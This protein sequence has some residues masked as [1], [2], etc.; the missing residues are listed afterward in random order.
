MKRKCETCDNYHEKTEAEGECRGKFPEPV[1]AVAKSALG[2]QMPIVLGAWPMLA[3]E[4]WCAQWKPRD[5]DDGGIDVGDD[6]D[7]GIIL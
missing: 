5:A 1:H 6:G 2:Q 7:S 4:A 3:K